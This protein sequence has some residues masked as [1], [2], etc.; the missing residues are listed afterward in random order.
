M[1]K[2]DKGNGNFYEGADIFFIGVN[3]LGLISAFIL[4]YV[5]IKYYNG[6]LNKVDEGD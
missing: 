2:D 4:Y 6:I 3:V 1:R 5:D